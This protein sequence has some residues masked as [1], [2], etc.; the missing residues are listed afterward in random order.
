MSFWTRAEQELLISIGSSR[1]TAAH[2]E[3]NWPYYVSRLDTCEGFTA[4]RELEPPEGGRMVSGTVDLSE[5]AWIRLRPALGSE[6][7][8]A[9][10]AELAA[11][12]ELKRSSS[13]YAAGPSE[14]ELLIRAN[15]EE[16]YWALV[17]TDMAIW[18]KRMAASPVSTQIE[19]VRYA[20]DRPDSPAWMGT[21]LVPRR[22]LQIRRARRQLTE[23]QRQVLRG[24]LA[25]FRQA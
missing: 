2:V 11:S 5:Y 4:E 7:L 24:R 9:E 18:Q 1:P 25:S 23:D 3:S 14:R 20:D 12:L 21:W 17:Q 22:A 6:Q 15:A 8:E 19:E 16:P 13:E 10:R